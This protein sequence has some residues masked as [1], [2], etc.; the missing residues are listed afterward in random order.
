MTTSMNHQ[1]SS[2]NQTRLIHSKTKTEV[3]SGHLSQKN[4]DLTTIGQNQLTDRNTAEIRMFHIKAL[5]SHRNEEMITTA[6]KTL[7]ASTQIEIEIEE[8][9]STI[10]LTK[11]MLGWRRERVWLITI[12]LIQVKHHGVWKEEMDLYRK[13]RDGLS[14][15]E[16][17]R[18]VW[19][20]LHFTITT[21]TT[22]SLQSE[23]PSGIAK[24]QLTICKKDYPTKWSKDKKLNSNSGKWVISPNQDSKLKRRK[25]LNKT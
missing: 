20:Q 10:K 2:S 4:K 19:K 3:V 22:A 6:T 12:C 1:D 25:K 17:Q 14:L 9:A 15:I 5:L 13:F 16:S 21:L 7:M 8:Q 11:K 23:A 24:E 18:L